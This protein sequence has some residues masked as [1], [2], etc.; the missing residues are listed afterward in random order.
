[1]TILKKLAALVLCSCQVILQRNIAKTRHRGA[2]AANG[3][4]SVVIGSEVNVLKKTGR[5]VCSWRAAIVANVIGTA[6]TP[7]GVI[8]FQAV[9]TQPMN[10]RQ[11][12]LGGK[13]VNMPH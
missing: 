1:M 3:M 13:P 10:A 9:A 4:Q 2:M 8:L 7:Q 6:L 5:L 12:A 11:P